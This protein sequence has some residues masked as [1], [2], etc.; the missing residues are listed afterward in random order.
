MRAFLARKVAAGGPGFALRPV[1]WQEIDSSL[2]LE[3]DMP[4]RSAIPSCAAFAFCLAALPALAQSWSPAVDLGVSTSKFASLAM[5]SSGAAELVFE[6]SSGQTNGTLPLAQIQAGQPWH[7]ATYGFGAFDA[8]KPGIAL[9]DDGGSTLVFNVGQIDNYSGAVDA[10]SETSF[11]SGWT[12]GRSLAVNATMN[13]R[14][15]VSMVR[16]GGGYQ[17]IYLISLKCT[18]EAGNSL[19]GL[20]AALTEAPDCPSQSSMALASDGVGVALFSTKAGLIRA[21]SRTAAGNWLATQ[22]VAP[23]GALAPAALATSTTVS[24]ESTLV[25]SLGKGSSGVQVW[26]AVVSPAGV[27][28]APVQLSAQA[29]T[30]GVAATALPDGSTAVVYGRPGN[31]GTCEAMI[32]TRPAG[33]SFGTASAATSGAKL[34]SPALVSSAAGNLILAWKDGKRRAL[35]AAFGKPDTMFSAPATLGPPAAAQ[36][37]AGGGY[38]N[39][40]WCTKHCYASSLALP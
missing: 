12:T 16:T 18:L 30:V 31:K 17:A 5:N 2:I 15:L 19:S 24:D 13:A 9:N 29:C 32:A 34:G 35:L 8:S 39:A 25:W 23:V 1:G 3:S 40:A 20:E 11:A 6:Y 28:G 4:T 33:G 21:A 10:Y 22:T 38:A 7:A 37:A 27:I 36:L 26:A 14:P